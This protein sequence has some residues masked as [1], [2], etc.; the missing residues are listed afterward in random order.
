MNEQFQKMNQNKQASEKKV[1]IGVIAAIVGIIFF[2]SINVAPTMEAV[3][4]IIAIILFGGGIIYFGIGLSAFTSIKKQFKVTVLKEMFNELMP[5]TEYK[6]DYGLSPSLVYDTEF[7][8]RADRFH[9][10]DYLSGELEGVTFVS[11]DVRLEERHVQHT[12]NGTRV[13]YTTYFLGRVFRFDFNKDFVGEL[14]VLESGYPLSRFK[15]DRIKLESV[16]FNKKFKTYSTNDLTAFYILTPDIMESIFKIEARNP[17]KISF[18]FHD[19]KL[20]FA[21]NNN[22]NTF[23]LQ[24]FRKIDNSMIEEFKSDLLVIK[25]LIISLKLNNKLFKK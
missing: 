22:K 15:Y 3:F 1:I 20:F 17:G 4:T 23:E 12:K 6:P 25:D 19:G 16:A 8:K 2:L 5:G 14:Q 21:I 7:L 10:E 18:S 11:S 24:M 13:Y 9:S